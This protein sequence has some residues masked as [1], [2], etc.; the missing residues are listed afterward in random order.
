[1]ESKDFALCS[2]SLVASASLPCLVLSASSGLAKLSSSVETMVKRRACPIGGKIGGKHDSS[3]KTLQSSA[4]GSAPARP[5]ASRPGDTRP[6]DTPPGAART[7]GTGTGGGFGT[8]LGVD[9][10]KT[11]GGSG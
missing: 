1:M 3:S 9:G 6:D 10:L 8:V 4:S 11:G 7:G 5:G 2:L